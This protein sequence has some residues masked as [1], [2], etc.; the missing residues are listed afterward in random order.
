[1]RR[2]VASYFAPNFLLPP[3]DLLYVSATA[4]LFLDAHTKVVDA[5][6]KKLD[7]E[8]TIDAVRASQPHLLFVQLGFATIEDDLHL[9]DRL[10]KDIGAPL[11]PWVTCPR[12]SQKR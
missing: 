8:A 12:C 6:A 11:S 3:T 9:C 7:E 10:R 5:I 4:K 1:M 2:F